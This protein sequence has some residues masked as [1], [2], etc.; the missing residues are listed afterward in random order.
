MERKGRRRGTGDAIRVQMDKEELEKRF[1]VVR[2]LYKELGT[3]LDKL[4]AEVPDWVKGLLKKAIVEDRELKELIQGMEEHRPP[5]ILLVGR[6]GVGKSSL[7]NAMF[8]AYVADVSDVRSGTAGIE[9]ITYRRN[10]NDILEI[11]DSRGIGESEPLLKKETAE[12][13][14]VRETEAFRPDVLLFVLR[15]KARDRIQEDIAVVKELQKEYQTRTGISLPVIAV[16]NQADEMEPSQYKKPQ[17]Y[18]QRKLEHIAEAE[19]EIRKLFNRYGLLASEIVAV[20]SLMDWGEHPQQVMEE[21]ERMPE[22][23]LDGRFGIDRLLELIEQY[24]A[25]DAGIG[26]MLASDQSKVQ[27]QLA[28]RFVTCFARIAGVVA[29]TPIPLSD[30]VILSALQTVMVLLIGYLAGERLDWK[31]A[32]KFLLNVLGIG[33]GGRLFRITAKQAAKLIPAAGGAVSGAVAYRGTYQI[34]MY[35]IRHYLYGIK[36]HRKNGPVLAEGRSVSEKGGMLK[37]AAGQEPERKSGGLG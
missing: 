19:H 29:A 9:Q 10:G 13:Q 35:A 28:M 20:S 7:I 14:L 18:P 21:E 23:L 4:P 31:G 37:A 5:R 33:V 26:L 36:T 34:G 32:Q 1:T 11:M 15:C 16:L 6:T 2:D 30:L 25:T 12:A 17:E 3:L 22:I 24:L 8:G 27:E